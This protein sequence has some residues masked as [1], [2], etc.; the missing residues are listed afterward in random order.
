MLKKE[1]E[2]GS[3]IVEEIS[4]KLLNDFKDGNFSEALLIFPHKRP[5]FF[6]E[7][8]ISKK[9]KKPFYSPV[10]FD[11]DLFIQNL[12][13]IDSFT[14]D[15]DLYFIILS[16]FEKKENFK[17]FYERSPIFVFE[18][19][20]GFLENFDRVQMELIEYK[21]L[22]DS[23]LEEDSTFFEYFPD[24]YKEFLEKLNSE[25]MIT[26]GMAYNLASKKG[27]FEKLKKFKKIYFIVPPGLTK[28][29]KEIL[30]RMKELEN[31]EIF[32]EGLS[33]DENFDIHLK[34]LE[35]INKF[36]AIKFPSDHSQLVN[37]REKLKKIEKE[38]S[39]AIV[40]PKTKNLLPLLEIVL[41]SFPEKDFN[42]S[43]GYPIFYSNFYKF[44]ETILNLQINK[45]EDKYNSKLIIGFLKDPFI[46]NLYEKD[47]FS[48]KIKIQKM[49]QDFLEKSIY[50][51]SKEEIIDCF[52][53]KEDS[54]DFL[55]FI[56]LLLNNFFIPFEKIK[57]LGDLNEKIYNILNIF[58]KNKIL[59][60]NP[61]SEEYL[62]AL[63]EFI[64]ELK[65]SKLASISFLKKEFYFE[66]F[67]SLLKSK[68]INFKGH[69]LKGWQ[70]LGFLET[71]TLSFDN[72]FILNLNEGIIPSIDIYD[73]VM[74]LAAKKILRIPGPEEEEKIYKHHFLHLLQSAKNCNL[75]Y[76]ENDEEDIRSRFLEQIIWKMEKKEGKLFKEEE[77][78]HFNIIV[79]KK[80]DLIIE[81]T[82]D[83]LKIL[84]EKI[85][86]PSSID[87]YL[88]CPLKFY[89]ENLLNLK[90][91][92]ELEED[93]DALKVGTIIHKIMLE[94]LKPYKRKKI[95]KKDLNNIKKG[96]EK[97]IDNELNKEL[98]KNNLQK[99]IFKEL[100]IYRINKCLNDEKAFPE[101]FEIID[102]E[103]L[104]D[105]IDFNGLYL[106]GRLDRIDKLSNGKLRV[107]DYKSGSQRKFFKRE[108]FNE[109][110]TFEEFQ[111]EIDSF[112]PPVYLYILK[113]KYEID[114]EETDV[115]F[116]HLKETEKNRYF[117]KNEK[118]IDHLILYGEKL[119]QKFLS[120]IL[121]K[122]Q[123]FEAKP[124]EER[125]CQY[126]SIFYFCK[127]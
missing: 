1:L 2:I 35:N 69:P 14:K 74:P 37:L 70:I 105:K 107:V 44:L 96:L 6:I 120:I 45:L 61:L 85:Y 57:D 13:E 30:K 65:E 5:K 77:G 97:I 49:E 38:E 88:S 90:E 106:K 93:F 111:N 127:S 19:A 29:E 17:E 47:P 71:R 27:N 39:V 53:E 7:K 124:K 92:E 73:P 113:K 51:I 3:R 101:E 33:L 114:Y 109:P 80:E 26:R 54:K 34:D 42:I 11:M 46:F 108:K 60:F 58:S 100:L 126:C 31:L 28:A 16:L 117:P 12:I 66:F 32:L 36:E 25:K 22:K 121:D 94:L 67:L 112:Q 18:W 50:Y 98:P 41:S 87:N 110:K 56:K 8:T 75:F 23:I 81:K 55:E 68:K 63:Y 123:P 99:R 40:L 9:L 79:S 116:Y 83:I 86:S 102:L 119:L 91:K 10:Y 43:L 24:L 84:K 62:E 76:I 89:F 72:I 125:N 115:L 59:K 104:I 122:N 118:D 95:E 103:V 4:N 52:K 82:E 20:K 21:T 64:M 48:F 78:R 15:L